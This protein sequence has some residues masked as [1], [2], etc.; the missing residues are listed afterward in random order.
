MLA[1]LY[2][3]GMG[4]GIQA[5]NETTELLS[6]LNVCRKVFYNGVMVHTYYKFMK[7]IS[8]EFLWYV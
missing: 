2:P 5:I 4:S 1:M 8:T 7:V 6:V 3:K